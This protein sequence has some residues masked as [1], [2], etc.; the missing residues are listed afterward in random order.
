M[1]RSD[2]TADNAGIEARAIELFSE[3]LALPPA[4]REAW[5]ESRAGDDELLID[6]LRELVQAEARSSGFL[7]RQP[8]LRM[9][10]DRSG[11]RIGAYTILAECA[12]GGM[13]T[14]YRG[15]R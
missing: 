7:D 8:E 2:R 13:S 14:V 6:Y 9:R 11:R 4:E 15:Q 12:I 5:I 10:T 3:S 1:K